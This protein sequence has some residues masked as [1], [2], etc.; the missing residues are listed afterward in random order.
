MR[1]RIPILLPFLVLSCGQ[2]GS[3]GEDAS[4]TAAEEPAETV[5]APGD[6]GDP[7]DGFRCCELGTPSCECT[8]AGGS[9]GQPGGCHDICDMQPGGWITMIDDN[10]CLYWHV[11]DGTPTCSEP[12]VEEVE[13]AA[14]PAEDGSPEPGPEVE[15]PEPVEDA[16]ADG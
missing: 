1:A 9:P 14:E 6:L 2:G 4:D 3:G 8:G 12:P 5:D 13:E 15:E 16:F 10:G 11:P 7:D